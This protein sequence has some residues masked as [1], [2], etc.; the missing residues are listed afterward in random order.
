M[1]E[2]YPREGIELILSHGGDMKE[3]YC[4][5]E[6]CPYSF[7]KHEHKTLPDSSCFVEGCEEPTKVIRLIGH[8]FGRKEPEI[9][10]EFF[11]PLHD[12]FVGFDHLKRVMNKEV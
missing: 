11:C 5:N 6:N 12:K 10:S 2:G 7:W 3:F 8:E 9:I 1:G 4:G